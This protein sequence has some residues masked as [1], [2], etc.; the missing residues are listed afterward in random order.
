M[1]CKIIVVINQKGGVAKTTTA[2]AIAA[3]LLKQ[4][5][6]VLAID[7]DQQCNLSVSY[8]ADF[9]KN[10]VYDVLIGKIKATDAIQ[11]IDGRSD[12]IPAGYN[13]AKSDMTFTDIGKE[14]ILKEAL[15]D[16]KKQYDYIVID[17]PPSLGIL[18]VNALT[19][20]TNVVIPVQPDLFSLQGLSLICK[21]IESIQKYTNKN[22]KISGI[23]LVR[24]NARALLNKNIMQLL[25][26][27]A[28]ELNT[29][30]FNTKIREC[31]AIKEAQALNKSIF[32]Y[33]VNSNATKDY[34]AFLREL[35]EVL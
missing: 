8:A 11:C 26:K 27:K 7:L 22:I 29:K 5:N 3:G 15:Q 13:L 24:Y 34:K 20:A 19:A 9:Y 18:T 32:E 4:N 17:T 12:I 31:I 1:D 10:N 21:N 23:L 25:E 35:S 28:E 30:L 14:Y 6:K 16:V 2:E 33:S